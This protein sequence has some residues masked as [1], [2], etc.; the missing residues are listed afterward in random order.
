MLITDMRK[1]T[2][3]KKE[4]MK[5]GLKFFCMVLALFCARGIVPAQ[6]SLDTTFNPGTGGDGLVESMLVQSDGKIL[7]CGNFTTFNNTSHAYIAR[8]NSD[9]SVDESFH[10]DVGYWVRHMALQ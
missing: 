6:G 3:R 5:A 8:L 9:G 4:V 7:I 10:A 2:L 1:K